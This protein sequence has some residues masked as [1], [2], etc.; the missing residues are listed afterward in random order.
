ME[1]NLEDVEFE[2][3]VLEKFRFED[4]FFKGLW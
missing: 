1:N 2:G 4:F 3:K